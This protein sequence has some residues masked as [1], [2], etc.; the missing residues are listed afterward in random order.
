MR[1]IEQII[2]QSQKLHKTEHGLDLIVIEHLQLIG[3]NK[4]TRKQ[5]PYALKSLAKEIDTPIVVLSRVNRSVENRVDKRPSI[6]DIHIFTE[7][8]QYADIIM[9]LYRDEVYNKK[10]SN[11]GCAEL[12][13]SKNKD[14]YTGNIRLKFNSNYCGFKNIDH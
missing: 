6:S 11:E 3:T 13:V 9:F 8:E 4:T 2:K 10:A 12:I 5:I 1:S 14:S 7:I